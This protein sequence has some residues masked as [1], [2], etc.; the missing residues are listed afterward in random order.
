MPAWNEVLQEIAQADAELRSISPLDKV[1]RSYL[2]E[3]HK[4][5]GRNVIAYYSGW[6][7]RPSRNPSLS[8]SDDD[9][10]AFMMC[11]HKMDCS[12]GLDLIIHTPGGSIPAIEAIVKYLRSKFGTDI[13]AFIPQLAMSAGTMMACSANQIWMGKQSSLGPIDPQLNNIPCRGVVNEF[14]QAISEIKKDPNRLAIWQLVIGKYHPTF[15]G[16]CQRLITW[17]ETMVADWLMTGMFES[18]RSR[19]SKSSTIAKTLSDHGANSLH[20]RHISMQE[21]Q[22]MGLN[23]KELETDQELQDC[24]LTIHHAFC[25]TFAQAPAVKIVENHMGSALVS[26]EQIQRN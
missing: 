8:I 3:L 18:D 19:K 25:H 1:R 20:S 10:N 11:V 5:T 26:T 16:E 24:V 23:I 12:K 6:L 14:E 15:L 13:R 2:A 7:Q 22:A 9:M 17:S 4:K 21:A